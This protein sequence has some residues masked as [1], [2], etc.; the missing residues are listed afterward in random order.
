M[1]FAPLAGTVDLT[2]AQCFL[3]G[4]GSLLWTWFFVAGLLHGD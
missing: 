3:A 4:G 1:G 2:V